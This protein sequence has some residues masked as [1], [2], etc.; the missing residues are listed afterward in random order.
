VRLRLE[1]FD[2]ERELLHI[3]RSKTRQPQTYP[4]TQTLGNAGEETTKFYRVNRMAMDEAAVSRASG[5]EGAIYAG[6]ESLTASL[7]GR[8]WRRDDGADLRVG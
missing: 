7:L 1:D 2:G 8:G 5:L 3:T 4:L 6:L